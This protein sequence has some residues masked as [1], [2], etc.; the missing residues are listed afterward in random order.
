MTIQKRNKPT[1]GTRIVL[2]VLIGVGIVMIG[3]VGQSDTFMGGDAG[4]WLVMIAGV[5]VVIWALS[6]RLAHSSSYSVF[7]RSSNDA[8]A[9]VVRRFRK[10][11]EMPMEIPI[12]FIT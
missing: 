11:H 10:E 5:G 1:S 3:S 12:T 6:K 8:Q 2:Y 9:K 7:R 4:R